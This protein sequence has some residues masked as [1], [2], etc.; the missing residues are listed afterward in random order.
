MP[1]SLGL[2]NLYCTL[3]GNSHLYF[4]PQVSNCHHVQ[5]LHTGCQLLVAEKALLMKLRKNTGYTFMNC[6]KALEKFDND[7]TQVNPLSKSASA[8]TIQGVVRTTMYV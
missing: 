6:K 4:H 2:V 5:S 7:I 8:L 3:Y 1:R